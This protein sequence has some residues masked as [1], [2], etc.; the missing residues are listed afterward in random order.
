MPTTKPKSHLTTNPLSFPLAAPVSL[1]KVVQLSIQPPLS[2][3]PNISQMGQLLCKDAHTREARRKEHPESSATPDH[4]RPQT[5]NSPPSPSKGLLYDHMVRIPDGPS[6]VHEVH[7]VY[8]GDTLT[9]QNQRRVRFL[10][11]DAPEVKQK[12]EGAMDPESYASN[13]ARKR[14]SHFYLMVSGKTSTIDFLP[15][16]LSR[17]TTAR[18]HL[19]MLN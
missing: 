18:T 12:E 3:Y 1:L 10:G 4:E 6:E 17:M 9:L 2:T 7:H 5:T 16:S 14:I 15:T 13:S 11:M 8:D 19:S